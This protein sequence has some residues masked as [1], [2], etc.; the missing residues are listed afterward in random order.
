MDEVRVYCRQLNRWQHSVKLS[1]SQRVNYHLSK[2]SCLTQSLSKLYQTVNRDFTQNF[3]IT[4]Q[5]QLNYHSYVWPSHFA[6]HIFLCP[7]DIQLLQ[8]GYQSNHNISFSLER[9]DCTWWDWQIR[10]MRG[11]FAD[12]AD[13]HF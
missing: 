7:L 4:G 3:N 12:E 13:V 5:C 1:K 11:W 6:Y 8:I 10:W 2:H 9:V